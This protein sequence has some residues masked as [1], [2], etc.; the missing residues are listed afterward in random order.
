MRLLFTETARFCNSSSDVAAGAG[1]VPLA[2]LV[3]TSVVLGCARAC[4][5]GEVLIVE[6]RK[7]ELGAG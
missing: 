6:R 7:T 3:G 1:G 2:M 4:L 5:L